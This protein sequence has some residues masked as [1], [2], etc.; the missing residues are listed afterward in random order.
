M[1]MSERFVAVA[2]L[3][4]CCCKRFS[5]QV[6]RGAVVLRDSSTPVAGA[7]V[8]ATPSEHGLR[9]RTHGAKGEFT[10]RLPAAGRYDLKVLRIGYRPTPGPSVTVAEVRRRRC[11][12]YSRRRRSCSPR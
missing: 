8:V 11:A 12:S 2:I 10:L 5:S 1:R 6:I 3:S 4:L 7:V 9:T